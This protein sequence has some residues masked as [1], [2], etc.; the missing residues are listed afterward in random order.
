MLSIGCQDFDEP[1][2]HLT[3]NED[4]GGK[5]ARNNEMNATHC[6]R[7]RQDG[8]TLVEL[9]VVL[10]VAAILT[11][12]G[13]PSFLSTI[14][15][16]GVSTR[17]NEL[18]TDLALARTE[19]IRRGQTVTVCPSTDGTSCAGSGG[20]EQGWISF[21]D[22]DA[23]GVLDSSDCSTPADCVL[24]RSP[25]LAS[26]YTLRANNVTLAAH[27]SFDGIGM[28]TASFGRLRLCDERGISHGRIIDVAAAG[29]AVAKQPSG[30]DSCE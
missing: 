19:A 22:N 17:T 28:A 2:R 29:R 24:R 27:L 13:V 10:S 15:D 23:S 7:I 9:M 21:R 16:N 11:T 18:I 25:A 14:R 4:R 1:E 8:F 6:P 12:I 20:W 3:H 5:P 26:G 30:S